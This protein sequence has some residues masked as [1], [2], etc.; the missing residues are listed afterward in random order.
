MLRSYIESLH[1]HVEQVN[2]EKEL[3][4]QQEVTSLQTMQPLVKPL[5]QQLVEYFRSLSP[6]QAQQPLLMSD[7]LHHLQGRHRDK[8]HAQQVSTELRKLGWQRRRLYGSYGGKRYWL[9]PSG[10]GVNRLP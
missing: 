8:P 2:K 1:K 7:L 4:K 9:P 5:E 10:S 6:S 3:A